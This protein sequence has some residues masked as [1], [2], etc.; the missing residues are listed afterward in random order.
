[1]KIPPEITAGTTVTWDDLPTTDYLGNPVGC[2]T[3]T[4]TYYLRYNEVFE[5]ITATAASNGTDWR[6]TL[7]STTSASM[8]AGTWY[9]SAIATAL[10]DAAKLEI[11]RGSMRV[12]PS[13][14]YSD[15]AKAFDGRTQAQKDLEAVQQAIRTLLSG[16]SVKEYRIGQRQIKRYDLAE[17][18]QLE[19]K[20]K[21]DVKREETAQLMANG[22]GNPRN[23]FVR[24]N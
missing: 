19:A 3:H 15:T 12:S 22:L 10:S 1:V 20:L 9:F 11:G 6:T 7:S 5:A 17:L 24:F 21:A 23:M 18:L 14:A 2:S 4:L 8:A 16:G 13:L